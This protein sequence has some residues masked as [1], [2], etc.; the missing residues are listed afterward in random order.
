[1]DDTL[2][3]SYCTIS[4]TELIVIVNIT[5]QDW[6]R[7]KGGL[8]SLQINLESPSKPAFYRNSFDFNYILTINMAI[9]EWL[10]SIGMLLKDAN[11]KYA[12]Y[13]IV[14]IDRHHPTHLLSNRSHS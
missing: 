6:G 3:V 5:G 11:Y 10:H 7:H 9:S 2:G 8:A 14:S 12:I 13:D 4:L 1:M